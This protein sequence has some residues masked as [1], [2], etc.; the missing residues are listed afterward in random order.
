MLSAPYLILIAIATTERIVSKMM[1]SPKWKLVVDVGLPSEPVASSE[2]DDPN[3]TRVLIHELLSLI[4]YH[5]P[6][7]KSSPLSEFLPGFSSLRLLLSGEFSASK[8]E[9]DLLESAL[10]FFRKYRAMGIFDKDAVWMTARDFMAVSKHESL[11]LPSGVEHTCPGLQSRVAH[12]QRLTSTAA[13]SPQ[14][15]PM[16]DGTYPA[17][18]PRQQAHVST[19]VGNGSMA[20]IAH[21]SAGLAAE[22]GSAAFTT[23]NESAEKSTWNASISARPSG[24]QRSHVVQSFHLSQTAQGEEGSELASGMLDLFPMGLSPALHPIVANDMSPDFIS[25][26]LSTSQ[27]AALL[28]SENVRMSEDSSLQ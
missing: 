11:S 3:E 20:L 18:P 5:T 27:L 2:T 12:S 8:R 25:L 14:S 23:T 21:S 26:G 6:S 13:L 4:H 15:P 19:A 9:R 24:P 10:G 28:Q 17:H 22:G 1:P 7:D 16:L